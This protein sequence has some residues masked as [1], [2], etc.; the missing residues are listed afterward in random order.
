MTG[1]IPQGKPT[2]STN[3][4]KREPYHKRANNPRE[5]E[6]QVQ[7]PEAPKGDHHSPSSDD[8]LSPRRKKQRSNDSLQ[9][10]F[11]K[12]RSLTYEGEVNTKENAK[13]WLLGM[14]K[15]FQVHNYSSEMKARLAIY[16]LNGKI[17]RW[18]RDLKH[19]NKDE[20]REICWDTFLNI[21]Q[22][23]YMLE[24]VL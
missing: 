7:T 4:S 22:E 9:G 3:S 19:T 23:K 2:Q 5:G 6:N 24:K 14:S 16:N 15:Y 12:I 13:E 10:G 8:S 20:L 17:A 21:L 11:Q 18:W 1:G